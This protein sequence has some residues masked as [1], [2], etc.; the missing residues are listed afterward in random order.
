MN[1]LI[2]EFLEFLNQENQYLSQVKLFLMGIP[3]RIAAGEISQMDFQAFLEKYEVQNAH[4]VYEKNRFKEKIG[5]QLNIKT[6]Q[7]SFRLLVHI[8][9]REFEETGRV[10]LKH[11]NEI[12]MLLMKISIFLK[13]FEKMQMEF[14]RLNSYL[15]QNDYSPRGLSAEHYCR[16]G[17]NFYGEA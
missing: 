11:T 17:R 15:F 1:E 5:E 14:K 13:N 6:D 16:P 4:M 3:E 7:V 8:G 12:S 2:N 9:H 10:L